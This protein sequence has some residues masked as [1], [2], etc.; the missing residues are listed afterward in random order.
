[1]EKNSK[2]NVSYLISDIRVIS[3]ALNHTEGDFDLNDFEFNINASQTNKVRVDLLT[4]SI[5]VT[6][7]RKDNHQLVLASLW[8]DIDFFIQNIEEVSSIPDKNFKNAFG[9]HLNSI[10][11]STIRGIWYSMLTGTKLQNAILPLIP[12]TAVHTNPM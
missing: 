1:M 3:F 5:S 6:L 8:V 10:C 2:I 9:Q 11:I 7:R 12:Q 4:N